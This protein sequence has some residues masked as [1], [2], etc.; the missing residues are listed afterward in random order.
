[1]LDW[2]VE[3]HAVPGRC[4]GSSPITLRGSGSPIMPCPIMFSGPWENYIFIIADWD[5]ICKKKIGF[6]RILFA[7][8][9]KI[10][11][12]VYIVGG[13]KMILFE[14]YQNNPQYTAGYMLFLAI[15]AFISLC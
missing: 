5:I 4:E 8:S 2:R 13:P 3:I 11:Y 12:T 10:G 7:L 14:N 9:V 6:M 15:C 1:V